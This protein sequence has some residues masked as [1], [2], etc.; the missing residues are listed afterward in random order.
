[1]S[2]IFFLRFFVD[3]VEFRNLLALSLAKMHYAKLLVSF[4]YFLNWC[5]YRWLSKLL[6]LSIIKITHIKNYLGIFHCG[7]ACWTKS[8]MRASKSPIKSFANGSRVFPRLSVLSY[9]V[10]SII[11]V[12]SSSSAARIASCKTATV[13]SF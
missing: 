1:M 11:S 7:L 9:L 6:I 10:C 8:F 3:Q 2:I 4:L 5:F 13:A 12:S